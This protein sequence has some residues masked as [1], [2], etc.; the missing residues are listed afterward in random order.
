MIRFAGWLAVICL[1]PFGAIR[2]VTA[3]GTTSHLKKTGKQIQ[4][5]PPKTTGTVSVEQAINQRRTVRRFDS[6]NMQSANLSQLLWAAQ[7]IT[8]ENG[9]KRAAPSAG[10]LYP[11]DLYVV[12]GQNAVE[13]LP[14]GVYHYHS[15]QH[16]LTLITEGDLR[17]EVCRAAL[18]QMWMAKA[19]LNIVITAE[20]SRVSIK[21][22]E[23]GVRYAMIEAGH[24]GQNLFLQAES[25][26]LKAGIAGAFDNQKLNRILGLPKTYA[27]LLIM[28]VGYMA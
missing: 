17:K 4:L 2:K 16:N 26:G 24:I 10:A 28:P 18:S 22:A 15:N 6:R 21:Y 1:S 12:A 13:Q 9:F 5:P 3:K 27:P 11:M 14:S 25:L 20:F 19:P 23:R 7:G 8:D